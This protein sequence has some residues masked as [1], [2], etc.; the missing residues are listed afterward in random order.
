MAIASRT[1][2]SASTTLICSN[3][4]WANPIFFYN[5]GV[6]SDLSYTLLERLDEIIATKPHYVTL[7]IGT[8]DVNATMSKAAL[9]SYYQFKKISKIVL[10]DFEG[11]QRNY[12]E[13]VRR[14]T[15]ETNAQIAL[16]SL[17]IMGEDL[18]NE[19]NAKADRYSE[20][21]KQTA[22]REKLT[23]LPV[24]ERMKA[25]LEQHPKKLQYTYDDTLK[26][27]YMSVVKH[28]IL[29][30]DWDKICLSHCMDLSQDN[31]HFN[32]RGAAMIASLVESWLK[33]SE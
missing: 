23:Y 29:G 32:T 15:T 1:E 22:E 24:R 7:L 11:Y 10:P 25:F 16:I 28:E 9:N 8:N 33:K 3:V 6:N 20:F 14:L 19:A 31:L 12:N 2:M 30:Q 4:G 5:A 26:L 27:V 13:I 18:Q 17:P 21:I